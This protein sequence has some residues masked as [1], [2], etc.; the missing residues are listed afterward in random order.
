MNFKTS[1]TKKIGNWL[2]SAGRNRYARRSLWF[3][4]Q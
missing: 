3:V 1:S 4:Q 2:R